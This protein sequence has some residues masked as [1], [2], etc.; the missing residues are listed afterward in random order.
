VSPHEEDGKINMYVI[1]DRTTD[2]EASLYVKLMDFSGKVLWSKKAAHKVKALSSEIALSIS[3]DELAGA[4]YDPEKTFISAKLV[5]EKGEILSSNDLYFKQPKDLKYS[6]SSI[7]TDLTKQGDH[8]LLK[9]MSTALAPRVGVTFGDE[10]VSLSDN[11]I[12]VLPNE[13]AYI[14]IK[15]PKSIDEL[16]KS[17]KVTSLNQL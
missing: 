15:S 11:F 9:V 1:S 10:D 6:K 16:E 13:P 17:L 4:N 2:E 7:Q 14:T 5:N 12:D 3:K 8:Y